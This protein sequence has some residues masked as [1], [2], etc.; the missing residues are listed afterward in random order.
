MEDKIIEIVENLTGQDI[1]GKDVDLINDGVLDS[2]AF[3]ELI[4]ELEDEFDVE[5]HPT[6]VEA[7]TWNSVENIKKMIE[8]LTNEENQN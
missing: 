7:N 1:K 4:S 5:I 2:L 6:Q 3:I 8:K